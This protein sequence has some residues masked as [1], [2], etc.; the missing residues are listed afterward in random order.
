LT[1]ERA[2]ISGLSL[3]T[4]E[5]KSAFKQI[6]FNVLVQ[7]FNFFVQSSVVFGFTRVL[8]TTGVM[9]PALADGILICACLPM[10]INMVII[11]ASTSHGDDGTAVLNSALG[12]LL[13]VFLSP[14][15]ITGYLGV[16]GDVDLVDIFYKL[17]IRVV[18]PLVVGQ[19]MQKVFKAVSEFVNNY[20]TQLSKS[21]MY[22]LLYVVYTVFCES[23]AN[24]SNVA[25]G[26]FLLVLVLQFLLLI[27]FTVVAWYVLR[28]LHRDEPELRVTGLFACT[29][30]TIS[31]GVPIINALYE[32]SPN[33]A[34]YILPALM[35][36]PL[37][38]VIG[39]FLAPKLR[40]FVRR[41]NER[42]LAARAVVVG[43]PDGNGEKHDGS[44]K[45]NSEASDP[46]DESLM[47]DVEM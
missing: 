20:K 23:F 46:H 5:F 3:R 39:S 42:L 6:R 33:L 16:S 41:E 24:Q 13:G 47:A 27:F 4:D 34:L 22:A 36:Y 35:W 43:V 31:L 7:I 38:L 12:N 1:N 37:Q 45:D 26:Y 28:F 29:H 15:L 18:V 25:V 19:V 30:K 17:A 8:I 2:V 10:A 21:Q 40:E 14:L 32:G 11:L 44:T 9:I